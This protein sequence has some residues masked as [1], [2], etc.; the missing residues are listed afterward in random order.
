MNSC[1]RIEAKRLLSHNTP[2]FFFIS[3]LSFIF[4]YGI[5]TLSVLSVYLFYKS[6]FFSFLLSAYNSLLIYGSVSFL[7][8][9][10]IFLCFLF[11]SGIRLGE[12]AVYFGKANGATGKFTTL[13]RFIG[14]SKSIKALWLFLR[15]NTLKILWSICF[16][17]PAAICGVCIYNLYKND[18][19]N[20]STFFVLAVGLSI[21][22]ALAFVMCR[23]LSLRLSA[24][25]YY[26]CL[27]GSTSV[28][29]AIKKSIRA[30]DCFLSDG[31]VLEYSFIGWIL[32]C[33]FII[34]AFY[35][36]PYIKLTKAVFITEAIFSQSASKSPY[37]VNYLSLAEAGGE[38]S[39]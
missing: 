18:Y 15:I 16:F 39:M 21:I 14:V 36:I 28:S 7:A 9:V 24:S 26:I 27:H 20:Q 22:L 8:S 37:A 32:S 34:P 12:Y 6:N 35:A 4:R 1:I 25:A 2:R 17:L 33:I 30:T 29:E 38:S 11:I 13:F 10:I 5:L 19:T 31:V 3:L 23:V